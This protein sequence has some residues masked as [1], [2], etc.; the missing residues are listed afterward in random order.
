M[1]SLTALDLTRLPEPAR[2]ELLD[3]YEFLLHKYGITESLSAVANNELLAAPQSLKKR[4]GE[5]AARCAELPVLDAR[6]A[7]EILGYDEHGLPR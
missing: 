2:T 3:F 5:I 1:P 7:D 4:L 6:S